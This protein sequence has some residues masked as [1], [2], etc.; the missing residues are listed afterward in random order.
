MEEKRVAAI[1]TEYRP[2]SHADV[3]VGK[4]VD[5]YL[6]DGVLTRPRLRVASLFTDQIAANDMS[7][8]IAAEHSIPI[9]ET[10]EQALTLGGSALAVDGVVLVGE[11][12]AYP[13]NDLGQKLYPRRRLFEAIVETMRTRG[14]V[15]PV[16]SDKHLSYSWENARWMYDTA[17]ELGI[18]FLAGSSLPVTWRQPPYTVPVESEIEEA[19]GIAHGPLDAY[20]FHAL[21]MVQ[22][23]VERRRGGET[24]VAAVRCIS[25]TGVR[26]AAHAGVWSDDLSQAAASRLGVSDSSTLL[27][28]ATDPAAF[29]VEYRDGLKT[30]VLML[31]GAVSEF[32]FAGR[33]DGSVVST[34]FHLESQEPF[35]HFAFLVRAIEDLVLT[36]HPP[37]PVERTLLTTGILALTLE[38]RYRQD[39]RLPTPELGIRYKIEPDP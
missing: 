34:K 8:R 1:V 27:D 28:R 17:R 9:A 22:C 38:S 36:G 7:R 18:P 32:S 3:I 29:V 23:M 4:L 15:V 5:P 30:T 20:G 13:T 26:E 19:L 16:F 11:H 25:G 39:I 24:G 6:L 10:I 37:Y 33:I 21:E 31:D 35:G 2:R 12:G 14:R